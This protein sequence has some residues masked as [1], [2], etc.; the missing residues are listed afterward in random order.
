MVISY[1]SKEGHT[2]LTDLSDA[3]VA[4]KFRELTSRGFR[5]FADTRVDEPVGPIKNFGEVPAQ[6]EEL[7]FIAPLAGG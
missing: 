4:Q 2:T 6:T 3:E 7:L 5:A 1:Q